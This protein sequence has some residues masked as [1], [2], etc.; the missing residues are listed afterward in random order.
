MVNMTMKPFLSKSQFLRG[1]QCRKSLW[2]HKHNPE[3][4]PPPDE[5]Q[6]ALFET[7]TQVGILAQNLFP[8]GDTIAFE[9]CTFEGKVRRTQDLIQSGS[10][11]IYEAT[12]RHDGVL[13]MVDILHRGDAGWEI[14]EVKSSTEVK[15]VYLSDV[16]IQYCVVTGS[17]LP[18]SR[19]SLVYVNNKYVR[20]GALELEQLFSVRDLTGAVQGNQE[21][22]GEELEGMRGMLRGDCPSIAIGPYC[23]K[24]YECDFKA[25]CWAH[26]P[27]CSVFS[28]AGLRNGKR[29][30]MY[31]QGMVRFEDIP[32]DY[33][34]GANQR[35]QIEAELT[36]REFVDPSGIRAFLSTL[37]YPLYFLDFETV[38]YAI[39]LYDGTRPFEQMPSQY[40]LHW[41]DSEGAGLRHAE[42]LAQEGADP[43]EELAKRLVADIPPDACVVT[44]NMRFEKAVINDLAKQFPAY[45]DRLMGV[46]GN[47]VDLMAPFQKKQLYTKEMKGSYSIKYVLPALAPELSYEGLEISNGGMAM[48]AYATLRLL[49]DRAEVERL[50]K[51]LLEYCRLDT[52]A[53]VR[54]LERLREMAG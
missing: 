43:R 11:T 40:S 1:L 52:L 35:K 14:Y 54:I 42:F 49:E 53:M 8:G 24:P 50:R 39:P 47:V 12:F 41:L 19:A 7:G 20:R 30:E 15:D 44:Y 5:S 51:A 34:L 32:D 23:D 36:G 21:G 22:I 28:L 17:G 25:H 18:A 6:K 31:A 29:F 9:G 16:I 45:A 3:L 37:R 13:V 38:Q 48:N 10:S 2:L 4:A 26:I 33:R 27:E 46:H